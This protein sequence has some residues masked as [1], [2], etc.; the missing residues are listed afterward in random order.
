MGNF[1]LLA[2]EQ[3]LSQVGKFAIRFQSV[4]LLLIVVINEGF[5]RID[6]SVDGIGSE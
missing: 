6:G 1:V 4:N 3:Q 2:L 5:H